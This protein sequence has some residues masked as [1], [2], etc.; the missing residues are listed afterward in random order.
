MR[1][2]HRENGVQKELSMSLFSFR[3]L[4][5]LGL[6]M[7]SGIAAVVAACGDDSNQA[8]VKPTNDATA[9]G[10]SPSGSSSGSSGASSGSSSGSTSPTDGSVA[11]I[12]DGGGSVPGADALVTYD[13]PPSMVVTDAGLGCTTPDGLPIRF[14]PMYSGFDGVHTYQVPTFVE[15]MDPSKLTWGSTDPSMVDIQPYTGRPGMMLTMKKAGDVVIVAFV[16]GTS[17]C[18]TAPLHIASYTPDQWNLG[19]DRY[20]NGNPLTITTPDGQVIDS[21]SPPTMLPDGA[22]FPDAA[23]FDANSFDANDFCAMLMAMNVTNPFENPPAA[24]TNCHGTM[25][26]GMLFGMTLFMDVQHTPEQTGGFSED[27]LT[28]VFVHGTIPPGGYFDNS[29]VDYCIWHQLHTW[30]DIDTPDKQAGMRAYLRSLTP[31]EQ[32]GCLELFNGSSMCSDGGFGT[33]TGSE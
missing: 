33:G 29:I 13:G 16:T 18:G 22:P 20:N 2:L 11:D 3:T 15:G 24:C 4:S 8:V 10:D 27:D 26:N 9:S 32:V 17:T 1:S 14:N 7:A 28:N 5:A 31:Q 23:N 30:T 25:S 12:Q 19:N 21:S 6:A